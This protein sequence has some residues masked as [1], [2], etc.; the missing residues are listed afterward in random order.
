M[1]NELTKKE[2]GFVQDIVRLGNGTQAALNNYDT[3]DENVAAVIASKNIRKV[4]IQKA[5]ESIAKSI[6]DELLVEKHLALLRKK[7]KVVINGEVNEDIDAQAVK[8]GLDMAYKLKGAYSPDKIQHSGE[9]K[10]ES[11]MDI[12][13][14]AQEIESRLREKKL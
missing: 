1:A 6:P 12:E 8:S 5:I 7:E 4:K 2:K 9:V 11:S 10:T 14:I 3:T 13:A